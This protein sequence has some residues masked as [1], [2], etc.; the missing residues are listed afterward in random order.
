MKFWRDAN[1]VLPNRSAAGL[2]ALLLAMWYAGA[3]QNNGAAYLLCFVVTSLALLSLPHAWA[4]L[5]GVCLRAGVIRPVFAGE[6][7]LLPLIAETFSRRRH[8]ALQAKPEGLGSPIFFAAVSASLPGQAEASFPARV[9]GVHQILNVK[10]TSTFPLGFFTARRWV[11]LRQKHIVYPRPAGEL[12]LPIASD[13]AL[14]VPRGGRSEGDDYAGVRTWIPGESMR[15]IDW[16]AVSR[17]MPLMTKQ[18]SSES[19][20]KLTLDFNSLPYAETE[21]KLSQL[22]RWVVDAEARGYAYSLKLP[23]TRIDSGLGTMHYHR[24][25]EALAAFPVARAPLDI[26][27]GR[28]ID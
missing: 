14:D 27:S 20:H 21:A 4:N 6:Q 22:A 15:Q 26:P 7:I 8:F 23:G 13:A 12:P 28:H 10:L 1:L 25:M 24:C 2:A 5:R 19:G 9:R 11:V 16:K 3:S 18:W 17:G